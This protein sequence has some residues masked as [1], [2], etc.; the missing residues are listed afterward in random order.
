VKVGDLVKQ[1]KCERYGVIVEEVQSDKA[2]QK[3]FR[4]LW[5]SGVRSGIYESGLEVVNESR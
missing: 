2:F 3:F 1:K 5:F 4:V